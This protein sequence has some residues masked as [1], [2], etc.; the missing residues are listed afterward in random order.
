MSGRCLISESIKAVALLL[1]ILDQ[2]GMLVAWDKIEGP[3]PNLTF[4]GYELDSLMW[5]VRFPID[6]LR[7]L[8]DL[9]KKH[10]DRRS[11]TRVNW[12]H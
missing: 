9:M 12:N 1:K 7:E 10:S 5:E 6:K 2:L 3:T 8:Q 4:L 11:C